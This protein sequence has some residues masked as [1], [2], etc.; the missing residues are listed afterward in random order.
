MVYLAGIRTSIL[1]PVEDR[2]AKYKD[3]VIGLRKPEGTETDPLHSE[4]KQ[5]IAE[6]L[7]AQLLGFLAKVSAGVKF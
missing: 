5:L 3:T 4:A 6:I 1:K 7:E 2:Y